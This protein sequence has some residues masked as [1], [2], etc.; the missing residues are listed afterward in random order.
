MPKNLETQTVKLIG[1]RL[2]A[3]ANDL[4][5]TVKSIVK[6]LNID[7]ENFNKVTEG[8]ASF[9]DAVQLATIFSEKYPVS[10][11]DL[12]IDLPDH[13]NGVLIMRESESKN[14]ARVFDRKDKDGKYSEYYEYEILRHQI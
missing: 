14:S 7:E 6:E 3:E 11:G 9:K 12:I 2:L 4:K 5:R 1:K 13:N 10:L 8:T